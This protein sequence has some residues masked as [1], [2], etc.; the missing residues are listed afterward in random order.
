MNIHFNFIIKKKSGWEISYY[1]NDFNYEIIIDF[2]EKNFKKKNYNKFEELINTFKNKFA[3]IAKKNNY[4]IAC[5][6]KISTYP[7]FYKIDL[8]KFYFSPNIYKLIDNKNININENSLTQLRMSGYVNE[9]KTL[10]DNIFQVTAGS[11]IS[12]EFEKPQTYYNYYPSIINNNPESKLL[13]E[14]DA[15]IDKIFNNLFLKYKNHQ[16]IVPLSGGLDSRFIIGK[17]KQYNFKNI[18]S[19]SYGPKYNDEAKIANLVAK[20][21][22]IPWF[23]IE[24][25]SLET[26]KLFKSELRKKYWKFSSYLSRSP[27]MQ[28][29][30]FINKIVNKKYINK[31]SV[32][33]NGQTG[34]FISGGHIPKKL[35]SN[36]SKKYM[37]EYIID[38]HFS[39]WSNLKSD[40]NLN[41]IEESIENNLKIKN[42]NKKIHYAY[43]YNFWE[44]KERQSKF[45]INQQKIYDFYE[46]DWELPLWEGELM[47]FW[48]SLPLNY[49]QDKYLYKKYLLEWNYSKLFTD[50]KINTPR[51]DR[52][53]INR[54]P[55]FS[56]FIFLII[57]I[58]GF[59]VSKKTKKVL[60][61]YL[62]F[63][64]H[65]SNYYSSYS[66]IH[67]L[68]RAK[69]Y[70]NPQSFFSETYADEFEQYFRNIK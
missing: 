12:N 39:L 25:N 52:Q 42:I 69:N 49:L 57:T 54:W 2:F 27:N 21:L 44:W 48:K 36:N 47:D 65:Y 11:Y 70:R 31:K 41:L 24:T 64:G 50:K 46:I 37:F 67:L 1:P 8:N 33:I 10:I 66:L 7:I 17:L 26:K 29:F 14:L 15:I 56:Y 43:V 30:D 28:E 22:N 20:K 53:P 18:I 32:I 34:D 58:I 61:N 35:I 4:Q 68:K 51:Y 19:F 6:D 38:K 45:V 9:N 60:F 16:I 13:K 55:G 59:F 5:V 62:K 23:F 40:R 3:F 63:F